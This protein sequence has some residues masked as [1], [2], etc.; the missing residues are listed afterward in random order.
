M[1]GPKPKTSY[2]VFSAAVVVV[3]FTVWLL[4]GWSQGLA[5]KAID[6]LVIVAVSLVAL[7]FSILA[8]R[9]ADGRVRAA[10]WALVCGL[11]AWNIGQVIWTYDELVLHEIPFPSS[12][13][14]FFLAFPV[15]VCVAL[16]L[17]WNRHRGSLRGLI[18]LDGLIV[19]G[20][21][22]IVS[23]S[24]VM[25]DL[26]QEG[27]A[28]RL[29]FVLS[30][31]Y[32]IFDLVVVTIAAVV[33]VSTHQSQRLVMTVLT[34]GLISMSLADSGYA[35]LSVQREY[36]SGN[37]VD[38]FWVAGL[39]LLTAAAAVSREVPADDSDE[40]EL[41]GW[42]SVWL[43]YAPLMVAA[44]VL[45]VKPPTSTGPVMVVGFLL[46]ALVLARQ[47]LAVSENRRLLSSVAAQSLHDPLTGL[48]NRVLFHDRLNHA[49]QLRARDGQS[50]GVL[51]IDLDDFKLVNDTLGHP[52]GDELL[53]A[54]AG[55]LRSA[56]RTGDT[57]SRLGG[58]EFGVILEG[59]SDTAEPIARRVAGAFDAPFI[60]DGHEVVIRPSVGLAVASTAGPNSDFEVDGL[61]KRADMAMYAAKRSRADGDKATLWR[62]SENISTGNELLDDL[63]NAI[64]RRELAL[65][66]QPKF[67]L[68]TSEL[69]GVEALLRWPRPDGELL[70][71]DEFLPLVR[72]HGL[73]GPVTDFVLGRALDDA[74]RWYGA[75]AEVPVAINLFPPSLATPKLPERISRELSERGLS[76]SALTVEITEDMVLDNTART[77]DVLSDLRSR[78]IQVAIDDFG[79]GYSALSYLRDLPVD[80][81]K[82]DRDFIAPIAHDPRAAA[83]ARA[84]ID[85]ARVLCL[86]TVAEGVED[87]ETAN[88]LRDFGCDYVQGYFYS[89]P[90]T[91]EQVL[92]LAGHG[93]PA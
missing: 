48:A 32:P 87:L 64:D 46:V 69:V 5:L 66:Y 56:V 26:Y 62:S 40:G 57:V 93:V 19:A 7:V 59:P 84:V 17:F 70:G 42:A 83:V 58:D 68:K 6:D 67:N 82:L 65:V 60:I 45:A 35:Y 43:P 89:L 9:A 22:F 41:P 77:R 15:A 11:V 91:A 71:P 61:L 80:Q 81:V 49:M 36:F 38:I 90:L 44:G 47:F 10:W 72:R 39:L 85:V 63:R 88:C 75:G 79:S 37:V 30:L 27:A 55:R 1:T 86:S 14:A 33:L 34:V 31:A 3:A 54:V 52:A 12:A 24:L 92:E 29:E 16:V 21:L 50:L 25:A 78:G 53:V 18:L 13:D 20:S 76:P 23:W 74:A 4:S 73:I 2:V 8:A 28:T 51:V